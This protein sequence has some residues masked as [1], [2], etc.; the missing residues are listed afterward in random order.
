MTEEQYNALEAQYPDTSLVERYLEI[1]KFL[2]AEVAAQE[3]HV[4]PHVANMALIE[5]ELHRRLLK[6][7]PNWKPGVKASGSTEAGTFFLKTNN[8]IKVEDRDAFF[9]F[10][11]Q[12]ETDD[13]QHAI[14]V[15]VDRMREFLTAHVAKEPVEAYMEKRN[16]LPPGIGLERIT[17][18]Q[19]RTA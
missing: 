16:A 11:A 15:I 10:I 12:V 3:E 9:E 18:L 8:S 14:N 6:R 4:K 1:R 5:N 2:T 7:N 19:V 13:V 17:K